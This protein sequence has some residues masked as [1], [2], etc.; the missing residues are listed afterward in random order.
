MFSQVLAA[1]DAESLGRANAPGLQRTVFE[2]P[3][4]KRLPAR[5]PMSSVSFTESVR[6]A[7][8]GIPSRTTSY[9]VREFQV[10]GNRRRH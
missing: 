2:C 4:A 3:D 5:K 10:T 9:D 6:T 8:A 1:R 7:I